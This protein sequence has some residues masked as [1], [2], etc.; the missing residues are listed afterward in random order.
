MFCKFNE[1]PGI[2]ESETRIGSDTI[3]VTSSFRYLGSIIQEDGEIDEDIIHRMRVDWQKWKDT[4][5]LFCNKRISLRMKVST[6]A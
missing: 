5:D 4:S 6:I 3:L 1:C 2:K